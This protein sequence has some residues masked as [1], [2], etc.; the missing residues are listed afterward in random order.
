MCAIAGILDLAYGESV[1]QNML[2][3]MHQR[4]PDSNGAAMTYGCC[5]LHSRLAIVD[6]EGGQQP[7][8]LLWQGRAYTLVYNGELYNTE[9]LRAELKK[10]GH[11]FNGYSDTEVVLLAFAQWQDLCLERMNGIFAFAVW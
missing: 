5:L 11:I 10:L 8:R 3:T 1:I 2:R 6:L 4:G 9:E 7:M